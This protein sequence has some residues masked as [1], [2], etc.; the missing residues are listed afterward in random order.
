M[1]EQHTKHAKQRVFHV[2]L[3]GRLRRLRGVLFCLRVRHH[4]LD[5]TWRL[6][7]N[8]AP[9]WKASCAYSEIDAWMSAASRPRGD[10]SNGESIFCN[11][12]MST[13]VSRARSVI[14]LIWPSLTSI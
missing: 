1:T 13:L 8:R 6:S 11:P 14:S 9:L 2:E 3:V 12:A 5:Y 4:A 7:G 10:P